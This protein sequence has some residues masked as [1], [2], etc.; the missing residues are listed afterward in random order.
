MPNFFVTTVP[1]ETSFL[2]FLHICVIFF[3]IQSLFIIYSEKTNFKTFWSYTIRSNKVL[4]QSSYG[5]QKI[6]LSENISF[7]ATLITYLFNFEFYVICFY[8]SE[9]L[10][11]FHVILEL[12]IPWKFL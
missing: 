9:I 2:Y 10:D 7:N 6:F 8:D 1:V 5:S 12:A 4:C 3:Y 11:L